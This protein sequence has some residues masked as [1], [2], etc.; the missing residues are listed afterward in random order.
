MKKEVLIGFLVAILATFAGFFAYAEYVSAYSFDQ[1]IAMIIEGDLYGKMLS[2]AAVPNLFIFFVFL[3]KKQD[4]R[5]KGVLLA[6]FCIAFLVLISQF[7][8]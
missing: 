7:Y 8:N 4:S 2:I 6:T 1:T 5:A 3:K